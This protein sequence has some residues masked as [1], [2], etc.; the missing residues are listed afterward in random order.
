MQTDN[1]SEYPNGYGAYWYKKYPDYK[2]CA[3]AVGVGTEQHQCLRK[4]GF[5]K[6]GAYCKQH[7]K[8]HPEDKE[9]K[10]NDNL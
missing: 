2:R 6:D 5:G 8:R 7:A 10:I 4:R 3:E 9:I 1:N